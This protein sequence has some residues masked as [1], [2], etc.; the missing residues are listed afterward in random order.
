MYCTWAI[1]TQSCLIAL[2][3]MVGCVSAEEC[4][5]VSLKIWEPRTLDMGH[6]YNFVDCQRCGTWWPFCWECSSWFV[7]SKMKK[8]IYSYRRVMRFSPETYQKAVERQKK[9]HKMYEGIPRL[10]PKVGIL[11]AGLNPILIKE[12]EGLEQANKERRSWE[13]VTQEILFNHSGIGS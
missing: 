1:Q 3:A 2:I 13:K 11:T 6:S 12:V 8:T 5:K 10:E 9:L 4:E 7:S